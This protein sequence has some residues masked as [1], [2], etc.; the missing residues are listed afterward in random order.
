MYLTVGMV[1]QCFVGF[2]DHHTLDLLRWTR[3]SGQIIHHDLRGEE[4]DTLGPPHFLSLLGCGAA[5]RGT[6]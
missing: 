4:E 5:C 3:A 2:I 6:Q 1:P